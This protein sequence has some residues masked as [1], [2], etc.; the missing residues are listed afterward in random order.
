MFDRAPA[1][2]LLAPVV[3]FPVSAPRARVGWGRFPD[4]DEVIYI[5][6]ADD[7]NVGYAVNL[8]DPTGSEWGYAPFPEVA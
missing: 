5:F 7:H 4:G 8:H 6:D 1:P 2:W 3:N